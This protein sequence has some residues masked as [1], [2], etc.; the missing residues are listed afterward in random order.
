ME[1]KDIIADVIDA[2][3]ARFA[4]RK[5]AREQL[6]KNLNSGH[7]FD[8]NSPE[9]VDSRLA[10]LS[11]DSHT[12]RILLSE[13]ISV[14]PNMS[15]ASN[16]ADPTALERILGTNDLLSIRFLHLGMRVARAV[17]RVHIKSPRGISAGYGTGFMVS[18]HL[19]LTN[20]HVLSSVSAARQS[21]AEFGFEV[22][23]DGIM[24][25][26]YT[27][28]L[29]P[30]EFF[31]TD[32]HLDYTL[33]AV[34]Q[35]SKLREFGWIPLIEDQGKLVVGEWVNIVQ[36]PNGEPKQIALRENQI[37]DELDDFVHYHTDTAP[38]SSG[39]PVFNDQWEVVAL[40]HSGVPK[41]D[42]AGNILTTDDRVWT[43]SMGEHRIAWIANEGVRISRIVNHIKG[44]SLSS[45]QKQLRDELFSVVSQ[46]AIENDTILPPL[47]KYSSK[48]CHCADEYTM[49]SDAGRSKAASWTI[50]L[51]ISVNVGGASSSDSAIS[52][53]AVST[54]TRV[55]ALTSPIAD[56]ELEVALSK[57][58]DS[59][60]RDYYQ[61]NI[62]KENRQIY[63]AG[64]NLSAL[65]DELF[66]QLSELLKT[67]HK[68]KVSYKPAIYVYPW[69]DLHPDRKLRSI[70]S[71]A[72][73]E[74][75][76][77]IIEDYEIS[78][79][80]NERLQKW[81]K[82]EV[83]ITE[84]NVAHELEIL[85]STLPYNCEHVVPQ[86]WFAKREPMKGDLHHLFACESACNSFRSNIPYF[87]F[88]DYEEA[89]RDRCGRRDAT[90][91]FE[92]AAGKGA[93][94]RATL[95]F[96]LRYPG[97]IGDE[98]KELHPERLQTLLKWHN[99]ELP[100]EYEM[101]RNQ[102]IFE[103]QG[104]RN[105]FIDFPELANKINFSHGFS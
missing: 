70:Y 44:L 97:V 79:I 25:Q 20:N 41:R 69:V 7:I 85:E 34:R 103:V 38:G 82:R 18:P 19:L 49:L 66:F 3:E 76:E 10:R 5:I 80:R 59:K 77:F 92:P 60:T 62:D 9:L 33:V 24:L 39:A 84:D 47:A 73:F 89:V 87:D 30:D 1:P 57:L 74:A 56:E 53:R 94:A 75:K 2:T 51:T 32:Q 12:A 91:K 4:D 98:P 58:V 36:H 68:N 45:G 61:E 23:E 46:I 93:V 52:P 100:G 96:L 90:D 28:E 63:Y 14:I 65:N 64:V 48:D 16:L 8:A 17:A 83:S 55:A 67:T 102:A 86:S 72:S 11:F 95:Y 78:K 88:P 40:H 15:G 21:K 104:N 50:P 35:S 99:S 29:V 81:L 101:H 27:I 13:G 6:E 37:V 105:P 54:P 43:A 22:G 31:A 71:G 26:S 42:F